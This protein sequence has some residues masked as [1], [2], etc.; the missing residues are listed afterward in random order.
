MLRS[1]NM[2]LSS[3]SLSSVRSLHRTG[4]PLR[5]GNGGGHVV[6]FATSGGTCGVAKV[7]SSEALEGL[8]TGAL[9]KV[10]LELIWGVTG[11]VECTVTG[12][13]DPENTA[14]GSDAFS[15]AKGCRSSTSR[16]CLSGTPAVRAA[17]LASGTERLVTAANCSLRESAGRP[18]VT[19]PVLCL[20]K[21]IF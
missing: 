7:A 15:A 3:S 20:E 4:D 16:S 18:G 12:D 1:P 10:S 14:G 5:R 19:P 6:S 21:S 9:G 8:C 2:S 13:V 11:A 17:L